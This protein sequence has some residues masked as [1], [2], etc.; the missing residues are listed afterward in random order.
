MRKP[1]CS[2]EAILTSIFFYHTH[3]SADTDNWNS[4]LKQWNKML[5]WNT[6][7][8]HKILNDDFKWWTKIS[9]A[10]NGTLIIATK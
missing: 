6:N 5:N 4:C 1:N 10:G 8:T 3:L 7:E 2:V 9:N